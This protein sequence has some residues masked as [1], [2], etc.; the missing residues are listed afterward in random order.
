[1]IDEAE[2]RKN[3]VFVLSTDRATVVIRFKPD[4]KPDEVVIQKIRNLL[5]LVAGGPHQEGLSCEERTK[6][7]MACLALA[8]G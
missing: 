4:D 6:R 7:K 5:F 2:A 1:M 3:G 8:E